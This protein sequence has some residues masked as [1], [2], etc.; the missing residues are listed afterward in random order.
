MDICSAPCL[1]E[2]YSCPRF[3]EALRRVVN[4]R[5]DRLHVLSCD[6]YKNDFIK[7]TMRRIRRKF[8]DYEEE[9]VVSYDYPKGRLKKAMF[10]VITRKCLQSGVDAAC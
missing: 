4:A 2:R 7:V 6:A 3:H 10:H 1:S 8:L 9:H 5:Y